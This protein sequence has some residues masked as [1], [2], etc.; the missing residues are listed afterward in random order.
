MFGSGP[1][2]AGSTAAARW[3]MPMRSASSEPMVNPAAYPAPTCAKPP[4]S[5]ATG[6][7]PALLNTTA[8][9]GGSTIA[10]TSLIMCA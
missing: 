3:V 6:C 8:A 1:R 10:A 7:R 2:A 4:I 9:G 5:P